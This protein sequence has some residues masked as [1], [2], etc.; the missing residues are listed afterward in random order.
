MYLFIV[1]AGYDFVP[2]KYIVKCIDKSII[3]RYNVNR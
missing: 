1:L 3:V 2:F